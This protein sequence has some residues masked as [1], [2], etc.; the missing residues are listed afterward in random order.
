MLYVV[1]GFMRTGT[2]MMMGALEAGGL[3]V[4]YSTDRNR[5]MNEKW[6]QPDY[7]PNDNY[8]ELG[9]DDYSR[10]DLAERFAG[11]AVK[12]LWGGVLRLP[13]GEYRVVFMR[14]PVAEIHI[15]LLAFFG[16]DYAA[17]RYPDFD[18]L[19]DTVVEVLRD[20]RSMKTVDVVQY[21]DMIRDPV[22]TLTDLNWPIDV[23]RAAKVPQRH[24]AR[25]A[26]A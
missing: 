9:A 25:F 13:V 15:S 7:L 6:G 4:A 12:C 18:K 22:K 14:R 10:G 21:H 2:S 1:S 16:N 26:S 8:Y 20:R 24:R 23:K 3:E 17:S 19:M 5:E 11:K